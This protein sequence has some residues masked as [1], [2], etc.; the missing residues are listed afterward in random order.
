LSD[1][2]IDAEDRIAVFDLDGTITRKDTYVDFLVFCLRKRPL[3]IFRGGALLAYVAAYKTGLRSNHWLKAR[4]LGTVASGLGGDR[5][6]KMSTEF[7]ARTVQNNFKPKA[8]T[9]LKR[10]KE[11]GFILVLAT[12]SF[13]FYVDKLFTALDMDYLLCSKAALDEAGVLTGAMDGENC[14]GPEKARR[15]RQLC[16]EKGWLSIERA[17]SDD[18][19]DLPMLQ[20]AIEALIVDPKSLTE[21]RATAL[22]YQML[23]WR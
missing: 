1:Q 14:I 2:P 18:I 9:E 4:F 7:S 8:L 6:E 12:A 5:L 21:S 13:D 17:Y 20:M 23:I 15:L 22:G 19:V 10:L 16:A 3:R 11:Q